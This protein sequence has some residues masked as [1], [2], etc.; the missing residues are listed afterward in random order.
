MEPTDS[1]RLEVALSA[2]RKCEERSLAGQFALE[3]MHE[4]RN[5]LDALGNLVHLA[6]KAGSLTEVQQHLADAEEQ[7]VALHQV[8][9]QSLALARVSQTPTSVDLVE[10]A[11]AAIR[12]HHRRVTSKRINITRDFG[13]SEKISVR[14]GEMV[15]VLSN[16]IGNALDAIK[17]E[18][19]IAFRIRK[20]GHSLCLLIADNGHG[21]SKENLS[22]LFQ[23]F[24]TTKGDEGNGLGLALSRKII[25]RQGGTV[26]VRSCTDP[27]RS[28]TTF[29]VCLPLVSAA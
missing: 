12:V 23:P 27:K 19:T 13:Q 25:D 2:L 16:L 22:R 11:Q 20:R 6:I 8:A 21:I 15:Q 18:G 17:D 24:F 3:V 29:R 9:G 5:P 4:I 7:I 1:E 14:P 26:S 10:L 28:G